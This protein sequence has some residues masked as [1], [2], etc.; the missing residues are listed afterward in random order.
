[1]RERERLGGGGGGK[2]STGVEY[3]SFHIIQSRIRNEFDNLFSH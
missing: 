2:G 3:K 1:M